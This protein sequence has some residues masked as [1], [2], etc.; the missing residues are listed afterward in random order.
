[1][2]TEVRAQIEREQT[3]ESLR[4]ERKRTDHVLATNRKRTHDL[5][6]GVVERAREQADEVLDA[7]REKA[8]EKLNPDGP[9]ETAPNAVAR[10][11]VAQ[12]RVEEDVALKQERASADDNLHREREEQSRILAAL[13]PIERAKTDRYLQTEREISDDAVVYR[14][15]FM[16]MISHE[17]RNLLLGIS[18]QATLLARKASDSDEGRR[19]LASVD[20]IERCVAGMNRLIGDLVDVAS[21]D[22]G[23]LTVHPKPGDVAEMLSEAITPFAH[24]AQEKGLSLDV[25]TDGQML[26]GVFD[27]ERMLQVVANLIANAMRFT[28]CG[29]AITLKAAH[30]GDD[31][32]VSVLDTGE[33]IAADMREAIFERFRQAAGGN[34]HGGLGLGLYIS[35]YI[36]EAQGGRIWAESNPSGTGSAF[37]LTIPAP[38]GATPQ[39][40]VRTNASTQPSHAKA[41]SAGDA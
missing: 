3:D 24:A 41:R 37:H 26:R 35:R 19:T 38:C 9:G 29:G 30:S 8:D 17:L 5:A 1:M 34:D 10:E 33:G 27:W 11:A 13:L 21:I 4:R 7:A 23:K 14:D 25:D 12:D 20:L 16:G 2:A 28:P 18:T 31:L 15:D 36:V 22:L 6:D 32:R 39:K 40:K